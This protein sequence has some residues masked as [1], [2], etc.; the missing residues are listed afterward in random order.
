MDNHSNSIYSLVRILVVD[1]HPTTASTLARAIKQS[2]P[3]VEVISATSGKEALEKVSDSA[4]DLV[5]TDMM[6]PEM[7]GLELIEKLQSHPG[8]RPTFTILIT[9]YDVPGL[10][11]TARRLK[12]NETIIKPIRA[13]QICQTVGRVIGEMEHAQSPGRSEE[14]HPTSRILVADDVPDNVS[15][16]ARYLQKEG[17]AFVTATNGVETLEKARSEMPDLI[18]LDVNMPEKDGFEV[19]REI[20]ADST[21]GHIPVIILTAARPDLVDIQYGLNLG[22]DDYITKPFDRHE[23]VARIR[24]RLRVKEAED[25]ILNQNRVLS[26]LPEIGKELSARLDI[27]ELT[28]IVLRRLVE[29]LGALYGHL[30]IFDPSGTI[31]NEYH[32]SSSPANKLETKAP[33]PTVFLESIEATHQGIIID[34]FRKEPH[35]QAVPEDPTR[36]AIIVP[37]FGRFELIGLIMLTHEQVG[38]FN[39]EH[40]LILQAI[41]SQ[42]AIAIENARLHASIVS[43]QQRSATIL[44][45][46]TDA[47]LMFDANG[48]LVL[49][50]S[51]GE[52]LF[53]DYQAKLGQSL[54]EV[55][56]YDV[57]TTNLEEVIASRRLK[58][59]DIDWPD[60]RSFSV[61]FTPIE[62]GGCAVIFHD[63]T[64]FK[65]LK[66]VTD[67]FISTASHNLKSPIT[68]IAG[69]TQL[70]SKTGQLNETQSEYIAQIEAAL[71]N[72]NMLVQDML[73]LVRVDMGEKG[74]SKLENVDLDIVLSDIVGEFRP[75]AQTKGLKLVLEKSHD[76]HWVQ[77]DSLQLKQAL[78]NLVNNAIKYT[79]LKGSIDL[80]IEAVENTAVIRVKDTGYGIGA[81]HLPFIF[82][83]FYRAVQGQTNDIEGNGLG[84]AIVKSIVEQ[85]SGCINVES[86]VGK[87]SCFTLTLPL[88]QPEIVGVSESKADPLSM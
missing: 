46:S 30:I 41:A 40:K 60:R 38:Y 67:E 54:D 70:L 3:E 59:V 49:M 27:N 11:V 19:L 63:V 55:N 9:A 7:N 12:V 77:G 17:Y 86:H 76:Q 43:E 32:L 83:R 75:Q 35:W 42:A 39:L 78:R 52:K 13:E 36:S 73:A 64:R 65:D 33:S 80:S 47:I 71:Q 37:L 56:E 87:G 79:P 57:L 8:G 25:V 14:S 66:R 6:M 82:D 26:L 51:A 69:F 62:D 84:L 18:L 81:D 31:F 45:S 20:R 24:A 23:L 68:A 21:I 50:N 4:V 2:W 34:D 88:S 74:E 53:P 61:Q 44:Q 29:T 85:H 1:D 48:C 5:I 58:T 10:K 15:L 28:E 22:A 16:L 72:L